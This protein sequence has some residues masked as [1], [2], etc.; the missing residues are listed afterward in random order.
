M[1][2]CVDGSKVMCVSL[3][4]LNETVVVRCSLYWCGRADVW[5]CLFIVLSHEGRPSALPLMK[6]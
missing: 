5:A 4:Y 2:G 1:S 6:V 3:G